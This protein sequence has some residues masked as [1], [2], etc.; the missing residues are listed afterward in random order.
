[1]EKKWSRRDFVQAGA[2][3]VPALA[4]GSPLGLPN[5]PANREKEQDEIEVTPTEDLMREHGLLNRCLLVYDHYLTLIA[6]HKELPP[7]PLAETAGIIRRF[8]EEYHEKQE[9]DYVF[10]RFE[11]ARKLPELVATLRAQHKAGREVTAQ[12]LRLGPATGLKHAADHDRLAQSLHAFLAMYRPHEARE[13]TVL[14]PAL[15]QIVSKHEYDALG[16]DFEKRE[17]QMFGEDGFEAMVEK[18]GHIERQLG[19]YELAQFTP[20][21]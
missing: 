12:I 15:H 14:F 18:I 6:S 3:T 17:H 20:R 9:E 11:K 4:A 1:M 19:I 16:E 2:L 5:P 8:I 7:Q 10:P 13:D 21:T